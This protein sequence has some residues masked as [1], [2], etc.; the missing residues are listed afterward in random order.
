MINSS[1]NIS[2]IKTP[3]PAYKAN[4]VETAKLYG[5]EIDKKQIPYIRKSKIIKRNGN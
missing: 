1:W 2:C 5:V 3:I 4:W